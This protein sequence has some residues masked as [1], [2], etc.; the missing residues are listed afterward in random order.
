MPKIFAASLCCSC[1]SCSCCCCCCETTYGC[2][3]AENA[4]RE[5]RLRKLLCSVRSFLLVS[6]SKREDCMV[7]MTSAQTQ[8]LRGGF[9]C[10][11]GGG[12]NGPQTTTVKPARQQH[13]PL[14]GKGC[15]LRIRHVACPRREEQP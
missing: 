14:T 10:V 2:V 4:E 3:R 5:L 9:F 1:C 6:V 15:R 8:V 13:V 7:G 12:S 11:P